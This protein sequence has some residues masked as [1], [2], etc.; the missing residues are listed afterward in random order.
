MPGLSDINTDSFRSSPS[1]ETESKRKGAVVS[2]VVLR[3]KHTGRKTQGG[4]KKR[5]TS[6]WRKERVMI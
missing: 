1:I 4:E 6:L 5:P 3:G 2:R